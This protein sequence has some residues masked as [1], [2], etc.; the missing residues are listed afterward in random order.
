MLNRRSFL[1]AL[2]SCP[3][4]AGAARAADAPHWEYDGEHGAPHWGDMSPE[5]KACTAG[6]EQS[7]I[8]LKNAI[9]ARADRL[10]IAWKKE[11]YQVVNN[12]HTIQLNSAGGSALRIGA[13]KYDLKQF[14]FH[15]P[16]E[17]AFGGSRTAMEVQIGRAHV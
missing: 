8:D 4:C 7:P 2:V 1:T 17:H 13:L 14:H 9:P 3:I 12:G 15:T 11:T 5:F 16:S 6:T 10:A